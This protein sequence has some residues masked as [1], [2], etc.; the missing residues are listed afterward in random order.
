MSSVL[1]L[2]SVCMVTCQRWSQVALSFKFTCSSWHAQLHLLDMEI[3]GK[4]IGEVKQVSNKV[5]NRWQKER[6]NHMESQHKKTKACFLL[7]SAIS[8]EV[9]SLLTWGMCLCF[10]FIISLALECSRSNVIYFQS[11]SWFLLIIYYLVHFALFTLF[12]F[13]VVLPF[14]FFL[15]SF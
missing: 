11:K 1:G 7:F 2:A 10:F 3:S 6:R 14:S 8:L 9:A 12:P 4:L 13:L 5:E 15:E